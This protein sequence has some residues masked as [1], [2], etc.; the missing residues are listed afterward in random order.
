M[1]QETQPEVTDHYEDPNEFKLDEK[2]EKL[3]RECDLTIKGGAWGPFVIR[4]TI[5]GHEVKIQSNKVATIDGDSV[6]EEKACALY[7]KYQ[8]IALHQREEKKFAKKT[9]KDQIK[10]M[11]VLEKLKKLL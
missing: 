3:A 2:Q 8:I 11:I 10:E 9:D 1:S 5:K 6:P 7:K 4:G